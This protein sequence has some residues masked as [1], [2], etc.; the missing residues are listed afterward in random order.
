MDV[1]GRPILVGEYELLTDFDCPSA[2]V[3]VLRLVPAHPVETHEHRR[4][5]QIY[6]ALEG[7]AE[8]EQDGVYTAI[9]PYEAVA[10]WPRTTHSA[11]VRAGGSAVVM[12]ISIPPLAADDQII[13]GKEET[14]THADTQ[15]V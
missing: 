7:E 2:S 6:V 14:P 8:I 3:R 5:M 15:G 10:V 12:N 13:A 4:S 9:R 1:Q 11:R